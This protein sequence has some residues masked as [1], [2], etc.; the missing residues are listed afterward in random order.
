MK[1]VSELMFE[2]HLYTFNGKV[3]KQK[4]GGPIGLRGTCALARLVMCSWDRA[5]KE[6]MRTNN[7]T[8]EEFMR[9]MDDGRAFLYPLQPG[10][11]WINGELQ[12]TL[13]WRTEDIEISGEERTRR[14]LDKSMQE[15]YSCLKFTTELGEGEENWL[16][17]LD[18]KIRIERTNMVSY[19]FYEKPSTT[20][21][22]MQK[23]TSLDENS[24]VKILSNDLE[25]RLAHTDERQEE[26]TRA[27]VV[28]DFGKK[29]LTSGYSI[30]QV[31]TI[32]LNGIRGWERRRTR[33]RKLGKGL[34]RTSRESMAGRIKKRTIGKTTWYKK[35]RTV[36]QE[37]KFAKKLTS[38]ERT[39][40]GYNGNQKTG[41]EGVENLETAAV[42]FV[43]GT[44]DSKLARE[45]REIIE[46]VK[47]ILGY[48]VKVVERSGTALKL[49]FPLSKVGEG[50]PCARTDCITCTQDGRGEQLPKCNQ[51]NVHMHLV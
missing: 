38:R 40:R 41:K 42:L 39:T 49:L 18:I 32:A 3:Y 8:I 23:R 2:T 10:W 46:R 29:L 31:R 14:A 26:R 30:H 34:F 7:I 19:R 24:K 27:G 45:L 6:L 4:K 22:M 35:K 43:E 16:P 47:H 9:Y 12:Y 11:R 36:E 17:T 37:D 50:G 1:I 28:D 21:V 25:R 13:K 20:N 15:V 44:K 5:W 48:R 33:A 51:R